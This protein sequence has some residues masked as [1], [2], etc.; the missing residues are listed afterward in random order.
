VQVS[1]YDSEDLGQ[2]YRIGQAL[3]GLRDESILIIAAGMAVHN[4]RDYRS[5]LASG[6]TMP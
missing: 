2:H 5:T 1:L 3:E 6:E 4:T